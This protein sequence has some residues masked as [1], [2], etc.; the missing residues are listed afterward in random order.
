MKV[1]YNNCFGGF[2][3][4]PAAKT[5]FAKKKGVI[6]FWYNRIINRCTRVEGEA[7]SALLWPEAFCSDHGVSFVVDNKN[8]DIY[9]PEIERDDVDLI[10]VIEELGSEKASGS[11]SE[12]AI[13]NIPDGSSYEITD[14]D[15]NEEVVPP[16]QSW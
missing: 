9:C 4:S 2:E 3:L 14:Y 11:C 16:R 8:H 12:L 7:P 13:A 6:L 5:L 10:S 1:A 15:G